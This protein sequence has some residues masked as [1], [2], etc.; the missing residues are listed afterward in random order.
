MR[1]AITE[2]ICI[3]GW[4][5]LILFWVFIIMCALFTM[6]VVDLYATIEPYLEELIY[7]DYYNDRLP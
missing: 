4:T 3:V 7:D 6:I 1:T 2:T 5:T